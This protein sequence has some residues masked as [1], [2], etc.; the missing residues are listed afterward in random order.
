MNPP[1]P[2]P[3][4]REHVKHATSSVGSDVPPLVSDDLS[5]ADTDYF[6]DTGSDEAVDT[7][8]TEPDLQD[9][10]LV[11]EAGDDEESD[12]VESTIAEADSTDGG[13]EPASPELGTAEVGSIKDEL[14]FTDKSTSES[15]DESHPGILTSVARS[16]L[17]YIASEFLDLRNAAG[18]QIVRAGGGG[19]SAYGK[20]GNLWNSN[21]AKPSSA[22]T[23]K[24][25]AGGGGR[26]GGGRGGG[27]GRKQP[28]GEMLGPFRERA[29]YLH[30]CPFYVRSRIGPGFIG[31][32]DDRCT[33]GIAK[34]KLK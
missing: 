10:V 32:I 28:N 25:K 29:I 5:D 34:G 7:G 2:P 30:A 8:A 6:T 18:V 14:E 31:E 17:E 19:A 24:Q 20:P 12:A 23:R 21:G 16:L 27:G 26:R 13:L 22:L 3:P 33:Q 15:T 4:P 11:G 1:I 9:P